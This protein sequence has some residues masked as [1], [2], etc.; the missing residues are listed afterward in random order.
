MRAPLRP[1]VE[2]VAI[3]ASLGGLHAVEALLRKLPARFA[4]PILLV[5]HRRADGDNRLV[6]LLRPHTSLAVC[7]PED[8]EPLRPATVYV[9][10]SNYHLLVE[11][12]LL[13]L[14]VDP[15]VCFARPSVDVL[16]ESVADAYGDRAIA[17]V[18]TGSNEDGAAGAE[19][20]KR[21][22]GRVLVQDPRTA[23][24]PIAPKATLARLDADAVL[25]VEALS[26]RLVALCAGSLVE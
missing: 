5:Q 25:P 3:G 17:V 9:A 7:E 4:T 21:A 12:G 23:E 16:F 10:P 19:A 2:I 15:P 1:P 6:E 13:E 18:L 11:R 20:I 8:K 22:G 26:E 14:S 24:S